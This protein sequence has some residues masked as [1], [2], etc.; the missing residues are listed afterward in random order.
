MRAR[1]AVGELAAERVYAGIVNTQ[2]SEREGG[3]RREREVDGARDE[4]E[5]RTLEACHERSARTTHERTTRA[6]NS[7]D[8]RARQ[9]AC[10]PV[11][12]GGLRAALLEDEALRRR[13]L[14][15]AVR[16]V[17]AAEVVVCVS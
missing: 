12:G 17:E 5:Q 6:H 9:Q 11:Y 7:D 10:R 15:A 13:N 1:S 16:S 14:H 4:V 3:G 2:A 8:R